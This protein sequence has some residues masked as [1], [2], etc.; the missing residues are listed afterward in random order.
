MTP[1]RPPVYTVSPTRRPQWLVARM[2]HHSHLK[3][4]LYD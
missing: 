4:V 3:G 2:P 1:P